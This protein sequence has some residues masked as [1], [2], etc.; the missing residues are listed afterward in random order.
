MAHDILEMSSWNIQLSESLVPWFHGPWNTLWQVFM[1]NSGLMNL[2]SYEIRESLNKKLPFHGKLMARNKAM[3]FN[4][5]VFIGHEMLFMG[6]S[7][8]IHGIFIKN[9][10]HSVQWTTLM[11]MPNELSEISNAFRRG[12]AAGHDRI[13]HHKTVNS[14]YSRSFSS[15]NQFIYHS[16]HCS[17][18]NENCSRDT[19]L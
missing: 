16:W 9:V 18:P 15:Y 8:E 4:F 12:K 17:R 10:V 3:K 13:F 6:Y 11:K 5:A 2:W 19:T 7:L 1:E 14:N